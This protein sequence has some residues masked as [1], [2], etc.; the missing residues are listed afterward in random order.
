MMKKPLPFML[1]LAGLAL[2]VP[3][4]AQT[5]VLLPLLYNWDD[6]NIPPAFYGAYNDCWGYV[7][8][9][10]REYAIIG[11]SQGTYFFDVTTPTSPVMVDFEASKDTTLTIHRDFKTYKHYAYGVADEGDNSLQIFDLQYLPDSVV[12]VYDNNQF[13]RR[14][15]NLFIAD[16]KLFLA[17]N[18]VGFSFHAMDVLSLANPVSPTFLS[19]LS[20]P[21]FSHVHDVYVRNDTAYCSNGNAGLFI[22]SYVNPTN[23]VLLG[24]LTA[25]PQQGYNHSSWATP[26]GKTLVFADETHGS[27]L[28]VLDVSNYSNLN[29]LSFFQSNLLNIPNPGSSNGSIPHNP[30]VRDNL[31]YVSY[32]HDGVQVYKISDPGNPV[33]VAYYDTYTQHT[34][35]SSYQ[36]CWGVYPFLPSGTIIASDMKNGL[37]LLDGSVLLG[38]HAA[39]PSSDGFYAYWNTGAGTF[40][41]TF[42]LA[43]ADHVRIRAFDLLGREAGSVDRLVPAGRSSVQL[44][45]HKPAGGLY[46]L[47]VE[48]DRLNGSSKVMVR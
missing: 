44:P 29:I 45:F 38:T 40:S 46:V 13:C 11:S 33:N 30:F 21:Q 12:K 7:D 2:A 47:T 3:V 9:A 32:Y 25:Y 41:V 15:H 31:C 10:G 28:K 34:D 6:N 27:A 23:P 1:C 22:Y 24:S 39:A 43:A 19:T 48:G 35:Y 14:C 37:F 36:G 26:D 4:K 16:D 42:D 5:P 17:S 20:N 18:T 8:S